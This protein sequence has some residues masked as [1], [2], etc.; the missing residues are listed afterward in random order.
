[1]QATVDL[2]DTFNLCPGDPDNDYDNDTVCGNV[3]NCAY[4]ANPGQE[5]TYP[6]GGNGCGNACECEGNFNIDVDVDGGDAATFKADFGRGSL[7]RPCTNADPCKG[8]FTCDKNVSGSDAALFKS[9]FGRN[10][11]NSPCPACSTSPWCT[12]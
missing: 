1:V 10:S 8:D 4:K 2:L 7:T 5:D 3:D 11:L 12:Y 6:P 9:D